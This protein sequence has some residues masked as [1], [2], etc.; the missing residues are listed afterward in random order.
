MLYFY[1]VSGTLSRG[2]SFKILFYH[3]QIWLQNSSSS[4]YFSFFI[5]AV[6]YDEI[7][8]EFS[9]CL[10][11]LG[12]NAMASP[13]HTIGFVFIKKQTAKYKFFVFL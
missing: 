11:I 5:R 2:T 12:Q 6:I 3:K 4:S 8:G 1:S 13:L 10:H 7:G 9:W